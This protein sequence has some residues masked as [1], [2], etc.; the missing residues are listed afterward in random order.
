MGKRKFDIKKKAWNKQIRSSV[1][2]L[3]E[4]KNEESKTGCG[5]E[6]TELIEKHPS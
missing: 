3:V 5:V 6:V 4:K 1:V 2:S